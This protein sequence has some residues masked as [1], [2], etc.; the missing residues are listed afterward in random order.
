MSY[1]VVI[2][3]SPLLRENAKG[4]WAEIDPPNYHRKPELIWKWEGYISKCSGKRI[5]YE[6]RTGA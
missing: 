1:Q 3:V 6:F 2:L 4:P 5:V